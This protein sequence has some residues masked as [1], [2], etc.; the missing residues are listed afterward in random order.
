MKDLTQKQ[1]KIIG[2]VI[3]IVLLI[4]AYFYYQKTQE[5]LIDDQQ[6]LEITQNET[7]EKTEEKIKVHVSG[8]VVQEGVIELEANARVIDAIEKAGGTKEEAD[9]KE[10]N[11]A[12]TL[13]DGMKIYIPTKEEQKKIEEENTTITNEANTTSK[14][15]TQTNKKEKINLNTASLE[16][17]DTLP[18]IGPSTAQ[19]I[20]DYRK[21]KGKFKSIEEIKEVSGIGESKYEKIKSLIEI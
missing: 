17:L 4:L 13:E 3:G 16:E 15:I 21:E 10:V 1:K 7:E 14:T 8:A 19:K 9:M 6:N 2:V 20:I 12:E 18:G 11:L 5:P